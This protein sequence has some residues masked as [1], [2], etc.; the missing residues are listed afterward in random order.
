LRAVHDDSHPALIRAK[1]VDDIRNCLPQQRLLVKMP[2]PRCRGEAQDHA[3]RDRDDLHQ[4]IAQVERHR[5]QP[6]KLHTPIS[7]CPSRS[8]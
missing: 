7:R 5:F 6:E 3:E 4:D 1:F 2:V 8:P